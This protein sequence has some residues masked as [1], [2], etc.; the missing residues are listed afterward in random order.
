[1][2]IG[3]WLFTLLG[4]MT[5]HI[6]V[7][8]SSPAGVQFLQPPTQRKSVVAKPL[9]E[10]IN[11]RLTVQLED[12]S[13]PNLLEMVA[14]KTG[15]RILLHGPADETVSMTFQKVP[16][17]EGLRRL[18]GERNAAYFYSSQSKGVAKSPDVILKEVL[19]FGTGAGASSEIRVFTVSQ[20]SSDQG[21][22]RAVGT[23]AK[24]AN[25]PSGG[26]EYDPVIAGLAKQL[27]EEK[28]AESRKEAAENLGETWD[29]NA[30]TPLTEALFQDPDSNVRAA[31]AK[32]LGETWNE[33]VVVPLTEAMLQDS[34]AAVREAAAQALG[35]TWSESAVLPL[36][37]AL[38]YD[39]DAL[40]REQAARGLART[41]GEE[42]IDAL[43]YALT[44]DPRWFVRDAVASALGTIGGREALSALARAETDDRDEWVRETA[45][46]AAV[47]SPK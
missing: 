30:A 25:G 6:V 2:K 45:A 11:G 18:L 4:C 22:W 5:W 28:N 12:V 21:N 26:G 46:Y 16:L 47:K 43:T 27:L 14:Q 39:S 20:S 36:I 19:I 41:V 1:M 7:A 8:S 33:H 9:V 13:L 31:A 17:E 40:V 32:A 23:I 15:A 3:Y 42:A 34:S 44:H 37:D 35:K 29:E 10:V 24:D 38:A